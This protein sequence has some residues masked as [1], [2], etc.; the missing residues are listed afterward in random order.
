M[1]K[2]IAEA[3][4]EAVTNPQSSSNGTPYPLGKGLC[5][6]FARLVLAA[7]ASPAVSEHFRAPSAK[8]SAAIWLKSGY[9]FRPGPGFKPEEGDFLYKTTGSGGYGHVGIYTRRGV[10]ENSSTLIGRV[11]GAL[12][13][14]T[15]KQYG[16]FDVVGRYPEK[17]AIKAPAKAVASQKDTT[18]I[19]VRGDINKRVERGQ[20]QEILAAAGVKV[21]DV[22]KWGDGTPAIFVE[23]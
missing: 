6:M 8:E 12:G 5:Q 20:I 3:A 2:K 22:G 1:N 9:G 13:F 19:I 23:D 11:R 18:V 10:A 16:H 14:R 21:L 4:I 7:G 17:Q 15:L